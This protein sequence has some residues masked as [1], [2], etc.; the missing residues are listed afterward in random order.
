MYQVVLKK[1]A[2]KQLYKLP[3]VV[4]KHIV[5]A[6]DKLAINPK[7]KGS[8]KL[9]A[10][11]DELWR[12]RVGDYRIIY[13]IEDIIKVVEIQKIGHRKDIYR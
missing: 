5:P 7:P 1:S 6:I 9:E 10:Q 2:E 11:K 3:A 13:L 12:V 8:K 4:T